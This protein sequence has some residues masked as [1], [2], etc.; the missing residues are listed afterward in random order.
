[1]YYIIFLFKF[2]SYTTFAKIK[3]TEYYLNSLGSLVNNNFTNTS[4]LLGFSKNQKRQ[5]LNKIF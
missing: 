1:M 5:V 2:C 4:T 3:T